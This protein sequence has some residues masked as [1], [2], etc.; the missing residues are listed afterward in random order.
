MVNYKKIVKELQ[1]KYSDAAEVA[2]VNGSGK[3]LHTTD[4][5]SVK[6]DIKTVLSSWRSGNAQFVNLDGIRYSVLQMEPERFIGTNR[7]KKGH[8]IGATT[9]DGSQYML[10]HIKPK[11]KGWFHMAYPAVARAAAMIK[12]SKSAAI[13]LSTQIN[14]DDEIE[15]HSMEDYS[16]VGGATVSLTLEKPR[17]DPLLKGEINEFLEWVQN[18]D[19][20]YTYISYYLEQNDQEKISALAVIYR[21]LT[22]MFQ[23]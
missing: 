3:I 20:F 17:I 10:A 14:S 18:P 16:G 22:R 23:S 5:W 12:G 2:V 7:K 21:I 4:G 11:A 1:K 19:G 9:P 13:E 15:A 6:S 8:L